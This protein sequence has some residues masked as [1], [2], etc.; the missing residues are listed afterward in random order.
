ME[1]AKD[2]RLSKGTAKSTRETDWYDGYHDRK[3]VVEKR[4]LGEASNLLLG[5]RESVFRS[6]GG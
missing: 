6:C 3:I 5:W 1:K 4:A 2:D